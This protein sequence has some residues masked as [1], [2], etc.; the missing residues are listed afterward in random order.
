[1][2]KKEWIVKEHP[3]EKVLEISRKL[4]IS[5]TLAKLLISRN[6]TTPDDAD[7]F[8]NK[9]IESFHSPFLMKDMEKGAKILIDA[10]SRNEKILIWGDYDVDGVTSVTVLLKYIQS[11]G[12]NCEYYIPKRSDDGYGLNDRVIKEYADKGV[13]LLITVDSGITACNEIDHA[14]ALGMRV[15]V[16]DHHECR[17]QLPLANAVINPERPDCEYPFKELA[18]VG[19]VFKFIC[20]TEMIFN[21]V[22]HFDAL[23]KLIDL[24]AEFVAIGTIADVMP[25][26]DENRLI[27]SKGLNSIEHTK[28]LGLMALV[29]ESGIEY[30]G[31][32]KK[33]SST[34]IGFVLAPRINAAGRMETS[35]IAVELF[36]TESRE[37]AARLATRL[38][39]INKERQSLENE[40]LLS[41]LSKLPEQCDIGKDKVIILEDDN[42]HH[43]IIGIVASRITEK[44]NLPSVLISF[45]NEI[46]GSDPEVGKGSARSIKGMNLVKALASCGDLLEKFGGH[47][48][49]AGLS[50]RRS[51]LPELRRRINEYAE[52]SF[53]ESDLV[54]TLDVDCE[55]SPKELNLKLANDISRLEPFGLSNPVPMFCTNDMKIVSIVSIGDGKHTKLFLEKHNT[56]HVALMF[57]TPVATFPFVE[58]DYIDVAFNV[59]VNNFK[60]QITT[61]MIVRDIRPSKITRNVLEQHLI[62]YKNMM[63]DAN[64]LV[65]VQDIPN[66]ND[67]AQIYT[68]LKGYLDSVKSNFDTVDLYIPYLL[69]MV[70]K[71]YASTLPLYKALIVMEVLSESGLINASVS[72][73]PEYRMIHTT[74]C[75][76]SEGKIILENTPTIRKLFEKVKK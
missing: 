16:T 12:G 57:G 20:A 60:N 56:V 2:L 67:F 4:N 55:L 66:R 10:V 41:A 50:V 25:I 51:N 21:N 31:K 5:S 53:S 46:V 22:T 26:I 62:K 74:L 24:Y 65:N 6:Y 70:N 15:V 8:L 32:N 13:K 45:K 36:L 76:N 19:V 42:W 33:I 43:G 52:N 3:K 64:Y 37:E 39:E 11:I 54:K 48:L 29:E 17:S 71:K 72:G 69:K 35:D 23:K 73:S 28:N 63:N 49:A 61:Q 68:C 7:V 59:D 18:G 38:G 75:K 40:S 9:G 58:G 14:K 1:M 34:T 27:V 47:E 30:S 44:Y